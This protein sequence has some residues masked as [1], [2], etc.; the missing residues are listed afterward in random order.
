MNDNSTGFIIHP[1]KV[2]NRAEG[3]GCPQDCTRKTRCG[4]GGP[5]SNGKAQ[6]ET[7]AG[8]GPE[9]RQLPEDGPGL[10]TE[11]PG[12]AMEDTPQGLAPFA[13]VRPGAGMNAG[14]FPRAHCRS[15][16]W[17]AQG[18]VCRCPCG[19]ENHGSVR[20]D[21]KR[22]AEAARDGREFQSLLWST[23]TGREGDSSAAAQRRTTWP[24]S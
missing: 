24:A 14:V 22:P 12:T 4:K 10:R 2:T 17:F 7:R 5:E 20:P 6:P 18:D 3:G 16:C 23:D 9:T 11:R 19:G 8:P 21:G 1:G 13:P 15:Q